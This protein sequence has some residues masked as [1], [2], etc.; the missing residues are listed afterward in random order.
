M[1]RRR[2]GKSL[3]FYSLARPPITTHRRTNTRF[4]KQDRSMKP[5][6]TS[7]LTVLL[8]PSLVV[9]FLPPPSPPTSALHHASLLINGNDVGKDADPDSRWDEETM[10]GPLGQKA[11]EV[12]LEAFRTALAAS[13]LRTSE[14]YPPGYDG[15]LEIGECSWSLPTQSDPSL[16]CDHNWESGLTMGRAKGR[17]QFHTTT[18]FVP[19]TPLTPNP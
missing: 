8:L 3:S 7:F 19:L 1:K 9:S 4:S 15:M 6:L 17:R 11:D 5:S 13:N 16:L 18:T 12:F 14:S 2:R 10:S